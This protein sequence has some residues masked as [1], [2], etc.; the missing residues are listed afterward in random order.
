MFYTSGLLY[1]IYW[2]KSYTF[3]LFDCVFCTLSL[4]LCVC[5]SRIFVFVF[6]CFVLILF[7]VGP[8][9]DFLFHFKFI[10]LFTNPYL[11]IFV[12]Q[13]YLF[14]FGLVKNNSC[15]GKNR[16]AFGFWKEKIVRSE[17]MRTISRT[18]I[19]WCRWMNF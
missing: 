5:S 2:I 9:F 3:F 4:S 15:L 17:T 12:N 10:I 8:S 14:A 18:R 7:L 1:I 16:S 19:Y 11:D 6:F 13:A